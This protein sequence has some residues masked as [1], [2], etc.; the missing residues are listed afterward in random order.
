MRKIKPTE[1]DFGISG[2]KNWH[3][4]TSNLWRCMSYAI[5]LLAIML[6]VH[7]ANAQSDCELQSKMQ[8]FMNANSTGGTYGYYL[9]EGNGPVLANLNPDYAFYPA[10]TMKVFLHA[11]AIRNFALSTTTSSYSPTESCNDDH[12][13]VTAINATLQNTLSLM[14]VNSN[15]QA[16][17]AVMELIGGENAPAGRNLLNN[18]LSNNFGLSNSTIINHKLG[19]G[20]PTNNPANIATAKDFVRFYELI[21]NST[22]LSTA[23]R[24][25]FANL[26]INENTA[27]GSYDMGDRM[28]DEVD[29]LINDYNLD[30]LTANEIQNFKNQLLLVHKHG[31]I[32]LDQDGV[33]EYESNAGWFSIP[34]QASTSN[35]VVVNKTYTYAVFYDQVTNISTNIRAT[36]IELI[37][38]EL[39]AALQS[40]NIKKIN[41][42]PV[43]TYTTE[44]VGELITPELGTTKDALGIVALSQDQAV[45]PIRDANGR[46]KLISWAITNEGAS[47][48]R[49]KSYTTGS[50]ITAVKAVALADG[51][52][53]T[54]SR[55]TNG[56]LQLIYWRV[57]Y[58]GKFERKHTVY[59]GKVGDLDLV[60]LS[61]TR[62][63]TPVSTFERD[64]KVIIWD[65]NVSEQ[66]VRKGSGTVK[67]A[68]IVSG[69]GLYGSSK[70]ITATKNRETGNL[71]VQY[72]R[73]GYS[74]YLTLKSTASAG[75]IDDVSVVGLSSNTFATNVIQN[76][77]LQKSIV[78]ELC[79]DGSIQRKSDG[80]FTS[81]RD[82]ASELA[83][84]GN[85]Q[86]VVAR[87]NNNRFRMSAWD[88]GSEGLI[89]QTGKWTSEVIGQAEV[90]VLKGWSTDQL[91]ITAYTASDDRL[92]IRTWTIANYI[93]RAPSGRYSDEESDTA[94]AEFSDD[95]GAIDEDNTMEEINQEITLEQ[96]TPNPFNE[97]TAISFSLQADGH[98]ELKVL[99]SRGNV[100]LTLINKETEAGH[101]RFT[102]S[103]QNLPKGLY[104]YQLKAGDD[105]IIKKMMHQ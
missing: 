86:V 65:I 87:D 10:S 92:K 14:M 95:Q 75:G 89:M 71:E 63:A 80:V 41:I 69:A 40:W 17:N 66:I 18:M 45:T 70:L 50:Q 84:Y 68:D 11:Y 23:Q 52:L 43:A 34:F 8:L 7:P 3:E 53:V 44:K 98:V 15:N 1:P 91:L 79:F 28:R 9:K 12:T 67:N 62:V 37:R 64:L 58:A 33:N 94:S 59:A 51:K 29:K 27:T 57:D 78:W 103:G 85:R 83:S 100:V 105:V 48:A 46:L 90:A 55:L 30:N 54:A 102:L 77:L 56:N 60:K 35:D 101:H 38:D 31:N 81:I 5:L 49:Q 39:L 74:G 76:N 42:Q 36:T 26:M 61:R 82:I 24:T 72:W 4:W 22:Y 32:D 13:G 99:D 47:I 21:M 104:F 16:T 97:E 2:S 96:N 20:G 6:A 19:C 93:P 88:Y 25:T 73:V